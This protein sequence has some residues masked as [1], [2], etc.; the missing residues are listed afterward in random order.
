MEGDGVYN[1]SSTVQAAGQSPALPLLERAAEAVSIDASSEAIVVADYG[2]SEGHNSLAPM[3]AAIRALR[4]RV[5]AERP[6]SV[7]HDDLPTSDFNTLFRTLAEDPASYLRGD[8]ATFASAVGRSFYEQV[9]PADS[10]TLGWSAWA[11]QWLSRIPC[12]IPD[13]LQVAYSDDPDA[14][15][16]YASQATEDWETFLTHRG[17]ELRPGG[18]LVVVTMALTDAGDFGYRAVLTAMYAALEQRVAEGLVRRDEAVRMAIPTVGRSRANL[19]APF[20]ASG[21]FAG[22]TVEHAAVF[23]GE[24]TI[25]KDFERDR[26]AQAFGARWAAFSRAS[27]VPTLANALDGGADDPRRNAFVGR[28]EA[29]MKTRLAADPKPT[30]IPLATIVLAK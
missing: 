4:T 24:D 14:R 5:G 11:V 7:V 25:W 15:A 16:A 20:S 3:A 21:R 30:I 18:R 1:R 28:M 13:Q 19:L 6:I 10:V 29:G 8:P 17:A 27:V 2:A 9:L 26:D 23:L 22:L 12:P